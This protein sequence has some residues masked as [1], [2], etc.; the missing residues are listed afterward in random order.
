M[1]IFRAILL[2][3]PLLSTGCGLVTHLP[4]DGDIDEIV[5]GFSNDPVYE[6]TS[7]FKLA[8]GGAAPGR[9]ELVIYNTDGSIR[10]FLGQELSFEAQPAIVEFSAPTNPDTGEAYGDF[11]SG[12]GAKLT[13][14]QGGTATIFYSIDGVKQSETFSIIIPPQKL[15]QILLGEARGQIINEVTLTNDG[16]VSLVSKSKTAEAVARVIANRINL[17]ECNSPGLFNADATAY[18]SSP[19]ESKYNAVIEAKNQFNPTQSG[20]ASNGIYT[21]AAQRGS[22]EKKYLPA[23]DQALLT[24]AELFQSFKVGC[25]VNAEDVDITGGA[26]AFRSPNAE[27]WETLQS[28]LTSETRT[29]PS[30]IGFTEQ[31]FRALSPIQILIH[32]EVAKYSDGRTTFIFARQRLATDPA[33]TSQP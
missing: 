5:E 14:K 23:Y 18:K 4:D 31:T 2:I 26:F 19:P 15:I 1:R 12:S 22:V 27:Q 29:L 21:A 30:G 7:T 25:N 17:I 10:S 20:D 11:S 28:A 3:L 13:P 24:A 33:V 8:L 9:D 6:P 16:A 32:P